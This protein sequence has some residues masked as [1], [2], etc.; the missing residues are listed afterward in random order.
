[1]NHD[2]L[3]IETNIAHMEELKMA[4]R[5]CGYI[6]SSENKTMYK[7]G[8][9]YE[10]SKVVWTD[11]TLYSITVFNRNNKCIGNFTTEDINKANNYYKDH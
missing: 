9:R 5:L 7:N 6:K 10:C 3:I 2:I 4:R 11:K 8:N 1:M